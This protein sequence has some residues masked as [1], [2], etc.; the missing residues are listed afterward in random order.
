SQYLLSS[1]LHSPPTRS[2][3]TAPS[4]PCTYTLSLH[5]ALPIWSGSMSSFIRTLS[6]S[7]ETEPTEPTS[8][9]RIF[10][11]ACWGS[12]FPALSVIRYSRDLVVNAL[13]YCRIVT[14]TK[15]MTTANSS[16]PSSRR[17]RT[18]EFL[19]ISGLLS[20]DSHGRCRPPDRQPQEEVE[21]RH[22]DDR[23]AH[24][25]ADR[26]ADPG[27]AAAGGVAVV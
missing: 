21:D 24:R 18:V 7:G 8:T 27:R 19:P 23:G 11:S 15:P 26:H 20:A 5:D 6:P 12:E 25:P 4:T 17:R 14:A 3:F 10:T 13:L 2:L 16:R 22:G 9:P 1:L